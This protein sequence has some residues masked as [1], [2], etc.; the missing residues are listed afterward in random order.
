M[1][2]IIKKLPS[3]FEGD[4]ANDN[5]LPLEI[6]NVEYFLPHF[7]NLKNMNQ[8]MFISISKERRVFVNK[9]KDVSWTDGNEQIKDIGNR[10]GL[11]VTEKVIPHLLNETPQFIVDN[12]WEFMLSFSEMIRNQYNNAVV[13]ITGSVGKSST[14]LMISHLLEEELVLENRG[15]HNVRFAMPLYLSKLINKPD[16]CALEVSINALNSYDSGNMTKIIKPSIAIVTSVGEAH[17]SSF[18]DLSAV[19]RMKSN[20]FEGLTDR[21]TA[22]INRDMDEEAFTIVEKAARLK[23]ENILTYSINNQSADVYIKNVVHKKYIDEVKIQFFEKE[24]TYQLQTASLGMVS[25]SLASL[26]ALHVL[27]KP[28]E[29]YL[30]RFVDY[31]SLPKIMEKTQL[32]TQLETVFL[33]VDDSHNAAVPSMINAINYGESIAEQF[34]GKKIFVIGQIMDLG[35]ITADTHQKMIEKLLDSDYDY[36]FGYGGHLKQIFTDNQEN[37]RFSW[38]ENVEELRDIILKTVTNDSLVILKGSVTGGDFSSL[39]MKIKK[40]TFLV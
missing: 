18:R 23:T 30:N 19:A 25:N 37:T 17:M 1:E 33:L 29:T 2:N 7:K 31:R 21:G 8:T 11:I 39:G 20:I 32:K 15:N 9:G 5:K 16:I 4:Y 13:A 12:T 6:T 22:I 3:Y 28:I 38:F 36:I 14:R 10:L 40:S 34:S 27:G 26:L 24:Y 35:R